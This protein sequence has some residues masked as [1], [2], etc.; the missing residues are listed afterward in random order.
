MNRVLQWATNWFESGRPRCSGPRHPAPVRATVQDGAVAATARP[1]R[2]EAFS[3]TELARIALVPGAGQPAALCFRN[4]ARTF[5]HPL[6]RPGK[7][8]R[9]A[10]Q[11]RVTADA[12]EVA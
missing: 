7:A 8:R 12:G 1:R 2:T 3:T 9:C 4:T 6:F 5:R 10:A 11:I